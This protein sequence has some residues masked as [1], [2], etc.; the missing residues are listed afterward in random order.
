MPCTIIS[1]PEDV[2]STSEDPVI[3]FIPDGARTEN[4]I[5]EFS[6]RSCDRLLTIIKVLSK[7]SSRR[8]A[9]CITQGV[10]KG[11]N[12]H[13]LFQAAHTGLAHIIRSEESEIFSGFIDVEDDQFPMQAI[14]H[15]QDVD[16]IRIDDTVVRNA[17]LQAFTADPFT[18]QIPFRLR[19]YSTYVI[20]SRLGALGLEVAQYLAEK[21]AKRTVL[22]SRRILPQ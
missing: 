4:E 14:K 8:K 18:S 5:Y 19:P 1:E 15:V 12:A 13:T 3:V 11:T 6:T 20:T 22:V 10:S 16:A 17:R 7:T 21:G 9:F 2:L